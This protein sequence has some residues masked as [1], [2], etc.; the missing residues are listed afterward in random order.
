MLFKDKKDYVKKITNDKIINVTGSVGSGKSTYGI[1]YHNNPDYVVIGFDSIGS[2]NDPNTLNDDVIE[3][4]NLLMKKFNDLKLDEMV[5]YDTIIEYI[6]S[7]NKYGIIEGGHLTHVN[8]IS[9]IKG[10]VVVKRTARFKCFYRSAWRDFKNPAYRKVLKR[11]ELVKRFFHCF[12]K[13]FHHIYP[14][15]YIEKFIDK[16]EKY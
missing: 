14:Q 3:L 6:K 9:K 5:Y 1:S 16:L 10:T 4:R 2:N 8:D 7:K 15:K 12:K 13:R 11:H